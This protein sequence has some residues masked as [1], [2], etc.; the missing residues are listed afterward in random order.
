MTFVNLSPPINRLECTPLKSV[1]N[2]SFW[3]L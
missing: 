3:E 2:D 1:W